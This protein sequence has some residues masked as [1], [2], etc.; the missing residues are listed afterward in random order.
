MFSSFLFKV[1]FPSLAG[2]QVVIHE[3]H[4]GRLCTVKSHLSPSPS[5]AFAASEGSL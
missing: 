3:Q 5:I 4:V 2:L 1:E